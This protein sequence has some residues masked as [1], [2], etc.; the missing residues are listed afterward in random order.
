MALGGVPSASIAAPPAPSAQGGGHP[1]PNWL[2]LTPDQQKK[3]QAR[4]KQM[5]TDWNALVQ[6]KTMTD[7]QKQA[8]AQ[9]LQKSYQADMLA[10]LTPAQRT[11]VDKQKA[12]AMKR[13][14]FADA[15]MKQIV[16]VQTKLLKSLNPTQSKQI[17]AIRDADFKIFQSIQGDKSLSDSAKQSKIADLTRGENVK[18]NSI[19]NPAQRVNFQKLQDLLPTPPGGP[20]H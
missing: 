8:K 13:K 9:E 16:D 3:M 15:R 2:H 6:D 12:E 1:D 4:Q 5:S 10:M 7:Q 18:I 17:T 14:S 19:L 20:P 11:L